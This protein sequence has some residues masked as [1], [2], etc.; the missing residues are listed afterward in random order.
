MTALP[1]GWVAGALSDFVS[2]RGEKVSPADFPNLPFVGMDHVEPH[3]TKIVGSVPSRHMKSRASRFCKDD[4]LYGRLRPY[5]NKVAQPAFDG[6]ASGEFIV[7]EGNELI[8]PGFLRYR[9][10]AKD[11]VSFASHLNEGDRPRVN[12]SQIG[13][14]EVLMPPLSEQRRIV[15]RTEALFEQIDQG[16]QSLHDA[17]RAIGLYRRSLLKSTFE[18]RLTAD[19]RAENPDK[20]ADPDI[21][22][23]RIREERESRYTAALEDWERN[24][25]KWRRGNE[26]GI[27]PTKPKHPVRPEKRDIAGLRKLPE[28]WFYL[29]FDALASSIR[30]GISG[31][32][33][34]VGPQKIFRISAVRPMSFDLND[35]RQTTDR[36][37]SMEDYRLQYGDLLFTRYNGSRDYVG[38][39]AMYRGDGTHVYPDKLIRCRIDSDIINVAY[40]E[41]ATNCGEGRS[42]IESRIRTTAG[43]SG[44][45]G[46]DIKAMPVPVCSPAEQAEIVRILDDYLEALDTLQAE[47]DA[48]LRRAETLRQSILRKAFS[49]KL[50][51]QDP[52]DEPAQAL[53][54]R[55]RAALRG[56]SSTNP[57]R[58]CRDARVS[59]LP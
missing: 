20:L 25:A 37:G 57:G 59:T 33:D 9:L 34:E 7:F 53:L 13:D 6:L 5:L 35:Y 28:G 29:S 46:T 58:P 52:D 31:K 42:H 50:V 55:I 15:E 56:S 10:H 38:V 54:D 41:G 11:F 48:N 30:N 32:P 49:G 19:W 36:D 1:K 22:L 12:F 16:I 4:V 43:Q 18:G 39:S 14:F 47:I 2:P 51:P 8:D 27:R 3:T 17:K 24:V 21:L 44:V 40:L 45:S 23:A 26:K